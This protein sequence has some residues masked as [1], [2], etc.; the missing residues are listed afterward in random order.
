MVAPINEQLA[1]IEALLS[2]QERSIQRA[3]ITALN[4]IT[5]AISLNRVAELL[6]QGR[7]D[8]A[9][10]LLDAATAANFARFT[11]ATTGAYIAS[12][13]STADEVFRELRLAVN[14]DQTND[15]AVQQIRQNNLRLVNEFSSAQRDATYQ[16]LNR[17]VREGLNPRVQARQFRDSIGLTARQELAVANYRRALEQGDRSALTRALRDRRSDRSVL[18]AIEAG[19][20]LPADRIDSLVERYRTRYI[21]YRSEVI[22][23]T[24]A[25]RSVNEGNY[26]LWRQSVADGFVD[27]RRIRRSW[28]VTRDGRLRDSHAQVPVL[29]EG[30][31]GLRERFLTGNGNLLLHPGD[32]QAPASDTVQCRC[33]V[34]TRLRDPDD[35][36]NSSSG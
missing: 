6:E 31:V 9:V 28:V 14:F 36:T 11:A 35:S 12:A 27:E 2:T 25:L 23:R 7:L 22:A 34:V 13:Q 18:R 8:E 26:E 21:R 3:F 33:S 30:G 19:R 29:N 20:P 1:R 5:D 10:R 17:G 32:A 16:A 24:E 4:N 15:F